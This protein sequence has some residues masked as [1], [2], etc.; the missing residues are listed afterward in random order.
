MNF[1]IVSTCLQLVG[2]RSWTLGFHRRCGWNNGKMSLLLKVPSQLSVKWLV[3]FS[4]PEA[5]NLKQCCAALLM[6]IHL[7]FRNCE[8]NMQFYCQSRRG[9]TLILKFCILLVAYLSLLLPGSPERHR[10]AVSCLAVPQLR[11]AIS[12]EVSIVSF[13][14]MPPFQNVV[15]WSTG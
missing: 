1:W 8:L 11:L 10:T 3:Q 5:A 13:L 4:D 9:L 15:L 2:L 14:L 7:H 12:L 6:N